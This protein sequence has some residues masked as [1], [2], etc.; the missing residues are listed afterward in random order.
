MKETAE[1]NYSS[2]GTYVPVENGNFEATFTDGELKGK[3]LT[4]FRGKLSNGD[5]VFVQRNDEEICSMYRH[6]VNGSS[7][8]Q[9]S[10]IAEGYFELK[11]D[12]IRY[13]F[14]QYGNNRRSA[15][16]AILLYDGKP[17]NHLV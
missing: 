2:S 5:D 13:C 1:R 17:R 10:L 4:F 14:A 8:V 7:L 15:D 9:T 3:S 6:I 16:F 11:L 12:G